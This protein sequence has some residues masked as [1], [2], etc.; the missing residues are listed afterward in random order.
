MV[1]VRFAGS[2]R[3]LA[4]LAGA[5]ALAGAGGGVGLAVAG[6]SGNRYVQAVRASIPAAK[7][8]PVEH[9]QPGTAPES[10]VPAPVPP[11]TIAAI[12]A[13][14]MP[15]GSAPVPVSP[16]LVRVRNGWLVSDGRTL[17]AVYAGAAGDDGRDGRLV[18]VRQNLVAGTQSQRVLSLAGTGALTIVRA[19]L[20]AA[21][22]R[23]AQSGNLGFRSTNGRTGT[24]DLR[25]GRVA[26]AP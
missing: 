5:L 13:T 22:E 23:S 1:F 15:G 6:S 24:L 10:T 9:A 19:P 4:L 14:V 11:A 20:G 21:V 26:L 16:A 18:I 17:V 25:L 7:V 8:A 2:R 12:P 3:R